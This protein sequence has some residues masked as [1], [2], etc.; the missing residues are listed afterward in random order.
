MREDDRNDRDKLAYVEKA[1]S[2]AKTHGD[3]NFLL[4]RLEP[5][6]SIEVFRFAV[7][8]IDDP[9]L[10]QAVCRA[11]VDMVNDTGFHTRHRAEIEP[12]LDKVI[13]KSKDNG[14]VERAKRYKDRR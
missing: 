5:S 4:T 3:K 6:R 10:D 9:N 8:Y 2:V 7:K 1:M 13:E 11:I 14:H 12:F